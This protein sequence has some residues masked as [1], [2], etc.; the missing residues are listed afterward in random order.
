MSSLRTYVEPLGGELEIIARFPDGALRIGLFG[1]IER[2]SAGATRA[3]HAR[4]TG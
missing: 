1:E 3:G 4:P 2:R